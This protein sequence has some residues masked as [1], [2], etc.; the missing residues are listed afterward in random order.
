MAPPK[1]IMK[2][3]GFTLATLVLS[4]M[5]ACGQSDGS[6]S[7]FVRQDDGGSF[8]SLQELLKTLED[9]GAPCTDPKFIQ[10]EVES[11][12][13]WSGYANV[14]LYV[15]GPGQKLPRHALWANPPAFRVRG[16]NWYLRA[17]GDPD[18]GRKVK[19]LLGGDTYIR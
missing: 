3:V 4:L 12:L 9:L 2:T 17:D 7:T 6:A 11:A 1:K 5:T 18:Y 13:C 14:R 8:Q 15:E 19:S 16:K 10:M